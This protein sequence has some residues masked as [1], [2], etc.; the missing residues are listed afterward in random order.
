[1]SPV[2]GTGA[3]AVIGYDRSLVCEALDRGLRTI[4]VRDVRAHLRGSSIDMPPAAEEVVVEDI[5]DIGEVWAGLTRLLGDRLPAE[6]RAVV[7]F[8][9]FAVLTVAALAS[10]LEAPGTPLSQ[11]VL[12]RDK[13]LQKNAVRAAG[14]PAAESRMLVPGSHLLDLPYPGPCV[15]KP[16]AGGATMSTE[17]VRTESAYRDLM[18]RLAAAPSSPFVAEDLVDVEQEWI[19]DGV[20]QDGIVVFSSVGR[21]AEPCLAFTEDAEPIRIYRMDGAGEDTR[22]GEARAV[23]GKAL[24]ALGYQNG[25]FHLELLLERGTGQ[26]V[27]GEC[28]A[29]IGGC[30][31]QEAVRLKHGFSLAGAAID[32]A[33]GRTVHDTGTLSER[34]VGTTSLHLPRGTIIKLPTAARFSAASYVE[35]VRIAALLGVN[36]TPAFRATTQWQGMCLVGAGSMADLRAGMNAAQSRFAE[37]SLV[38][39]TFDTGVRQIEFMRAMLGGQHDGHA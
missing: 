22:C 27:F 14:V 4:V 19:V 33:L 25:V 9:E 15:V 6:L 23:A 20:V 38:A 36:D 31:I 28:A 16:V 13:F 35:D 26:F 30:M 1:M 2:N 17:A 24:Q 37:Q 8:D 39:P 3:V 34:C 32:V 10:L 7:T 12:M 29:R 21:Y 18:R 11:A 5:T